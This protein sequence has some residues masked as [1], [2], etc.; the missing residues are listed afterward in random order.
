MLKAL[1]EENILDN[2]VIIFS[3]DNGAISNKFNLPFRGTKY[4]SLEGGHRV[5]FIIYSTQI[6][7]PRQ[8]DDFATAMDVFPTISKLVGV[9]LPTDRDY[10][11]INLD[12][13]DERGKAQA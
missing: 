10:D 6:R 3:S 12:T 7:K 4:V 9:D 5:P 2:T 8:V 1:E 11:G 13:V